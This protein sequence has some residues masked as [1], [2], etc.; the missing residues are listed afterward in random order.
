MRRGG[1]TFVLILAQTDAAAAEE[2]AHQLRGA[3][4]AVP[5]TLEDDASVQ[6]TVSIGVAGWDGRERAMELLQRADAAMKEAKK[7]GRNL[8]VTAPPGG[9]P[10]PS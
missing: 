2:L 7:R 1:G 8:V 5:F 6:Q 10:E 9:S 3:V 4:E